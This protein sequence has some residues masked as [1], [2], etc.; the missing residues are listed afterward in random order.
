MCKCTTVIH[1]YYHLRKAVSMCSVL[2]ITEPVKPLKPLFIPLKRY[3]YKHSPKIHFSY[4][5]AKYVYETLE[6][7]WKR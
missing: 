1:N 7:R 2:H 5:S 4:E 3:D 6:N